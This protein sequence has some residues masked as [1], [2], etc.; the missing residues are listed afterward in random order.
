MFCP[1]KHVIIIPSAAVG[2]YNNKCKSGSTRLHTLNLKATTSFTKHK[3]FLTIRYATNAA[4][5]LW[6]KENLGLK[7]VNYL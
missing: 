5:K 1:G 4:E 6:I 7:I 2:A 3:K